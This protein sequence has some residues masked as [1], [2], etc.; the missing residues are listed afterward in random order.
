[1]NGMAQDQWEQ[2]RRLSRAYLEAF[3]KV[4]RSIE[5]ELSQWCEAVGKESL[6]LA[7]A[8][9]NLAREAQLAEMRGQLNDVLAQHAW[10]VPPLLSPEEVKQLHQIAVV[11]GDVC[12]GIE[13]LV[14]YCDEGVVEEIVETACRHKAFASRIPILRQALEAHKDGKFALSIPVFLA[15]AEGAYL[16]ML[17]AHG[18]SD[19]WTYLFNKE[20]WNSIDKLIGELPCTEI[21]L[22]ETLRAFSTVMC[23]QFVARVRSFQDLE[24]L[25]AKY[26]EGFLSRHAVLHGRD[27]G[28]ATKENSIRAAF[29]LDTVRE[30]ISLMLP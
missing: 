21:V 9:Q 2:A 29:I 19:R 13:K 17:E 15:Q 11:N 10:F 24:Q 23:E 6:R 18:V 5:V 7:M 8:V 20:E 22:A 28:Y 30:I 16:E 14:A 1:L 3:P 26:P 4:M 12:A 25:K 27:V